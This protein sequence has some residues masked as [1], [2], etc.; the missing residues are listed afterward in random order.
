VDWLERSRTISTG[1]RS[2]K[3]M[4]TQMQWKERTMPHVVV[5]LCPGKSNT[6]ESTRSEITD[7]SCLSQLWC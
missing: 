7:S 6:E 2:E 5:K 4:S 3:A 1:L